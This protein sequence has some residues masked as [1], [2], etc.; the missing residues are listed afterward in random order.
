MIGAVV[1]HDDQ[2]RNLVFRRRPQRARRHHQIAVG[3]NRHADAP[4]LPVGERRAHR[5][6]RVVADALGAGAADVLVVLG[7]VPQPQ[8][9]VHPAGHERPVLVLELRP[10]L[11]RQ[12]RGADRARVPAV[13]CVG[14]RPL[15]R[16]RGSLR[17]PA[18]RAAERFRRVAGR[19]PSSPPRSAPAAWLRRRR[20]S[21]CRP[22]RSA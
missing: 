21:T 8:R 16:L 22:R 20:R 1:L 14:A 19:Q 18:R 7:E 12:P 10:Q 4:V 17:P 13:G 11:H 2:K 9:P 5:R 3:L 15:E 6:R